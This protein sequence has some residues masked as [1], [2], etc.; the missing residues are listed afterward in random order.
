MTYQGPDANFQCA[1]P[2]IRLH[3]Y[4][5]R[6]STTIITGPHPPTHNSQSV[7]QMA[8]STSAKS[9]RHMSC[10]RAL[11]FHWIAS[12]G[13]LLD[14]TSD[15]GTQFMSNLWTTIAKLLGNKLYHTTTYHLQACTT[16]LETYSL[17][18]LETTLEPIKLRD[19]SMEFNRQH[20]G[21]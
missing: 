6:G 19:S 12:F 5:H 14:I 13:I 20:L 7:Y 15:R 16:F 1:T 4:R 21:C 8:G 18:R 17:S 9:N 3:Q 11:I 2:A 10:A